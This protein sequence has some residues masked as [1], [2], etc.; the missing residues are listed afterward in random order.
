MVSFGAIAKRLP[1]GGA[2]W[3]IQFR[4]MPPGLQGLMMTRSFTNVPVKE[5]L[6]IIEGSNLQRQWNILDV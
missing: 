6:N 4:N 2:E 1:P 5:T 3:R